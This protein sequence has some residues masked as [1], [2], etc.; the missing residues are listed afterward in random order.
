MCVYACVCEC[1]VYYI[2]GYACVGMYMLSVSMCVCT[3]VY[4][5]VCMWCVHVYGCMFVWVHTFGCVVQRYGPVWWDLDTLREIQICARYRLDTLAIRRPIYGMIRRS[6]PV[7]AVKIRWRFGSKIAS[8]HVS[9][10][11]LVYFNFSIY[12][13]YFMRMYIWFLDYSVHA[14]DYCYTMVH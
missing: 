6:V 8:F 13:Y 10:C 2:Y 4:I 14:G 1:C 11:L 9:V 12:S 7:R 3:Y 5:R